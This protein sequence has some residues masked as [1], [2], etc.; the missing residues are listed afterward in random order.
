MPNY[1]KICAQSCAHSTR[2]PCE[3]RLSLF[4]C[5]PWPPAL[6]RREGGCPTAGRV[7]AGRGVGCGACTLWRSAASASAMSFSRSLIMRRSASSCWI[8][9]CRGRVLPEWK[10]ALARCTTS[11]ILLMVPEGRQHLGAG[12]DDGLR[13]APRPIT[14]TCGHWGPRGQHPH[15][16]S[17]GLILQEEEDLPGSAG[18]EAFFGL[19]CSLTQMPGPFW[20]AWYALSTWPPCLKEGQCVGT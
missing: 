10:A 12:Q 15:C 7:L 13:P 8:R 6:W 2:P 11:L 18:D 4:L 9:N 19:C 14:R 17:N 1:A 3:Q 5:H 20:P 16:S